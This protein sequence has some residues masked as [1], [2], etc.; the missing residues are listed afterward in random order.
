MKVGIIVDGQ[1]EYGTIPNLLG[2]LG[3][4][5]QYK[6]LY[7]DIQPK[8]V[9]K[10]V[11][12]AAKTAMAFFTKNDFDRIVVI[13]DL[14]DLAECPVTRAR[15][16]E[17]AFQAVYGTPVSCVVKVRSVENWLIADP[18]SIN[19]ELHKS[20]EVSTTNAQLVIPDKADN[21][22]N[23]L[24]ILKSSKSSQ[25]GSY[26]KVADGIRISKVINPWVVAENSRCFRRFLRTVGCPSFS[27]QSKLPPSK[28]VPA[29]AVTTGQV[30]VTQTKPAPPK[31]PRRK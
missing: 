24:G 7:A 2:T 12:N 8:S 9:P 31:K 5:P 27:T 30:A 16:V 23:A 25:K 20:Y 17:A 19:R 3:E 14:E 6:V 11:A 18:A 22:R 13:I 10:K 28:V 29:V 1:T 26:E 4:A 15:N 21:V